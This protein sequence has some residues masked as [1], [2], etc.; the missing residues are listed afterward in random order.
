[1][2]KPLYH[3]SLREQIANKCIHFNGVMNDTCKAG[4]DY[5]QFRKQSTPDKPVGFPCLRDCENAP[6]CEK[7][8]WPSEEHIKARLDEIEQSTQRHLKAAEV[9]D[10]FRKRHKGKSAREAVPCPA[11]GTGTL[12]LSISSYNGHVWGKCSTPDCLAWIE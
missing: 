1:M 12:H 2:G 9:V 8:E 5:E 3:K 4:V 6:A 7:R 10:A 11:C